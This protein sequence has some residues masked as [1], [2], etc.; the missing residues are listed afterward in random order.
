MKSK[1]SQVKE[2]A[3][4]QAKCKC[5]AKNCSCKSQEEVSEKK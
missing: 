2:N 1:K 4:K 5:K 3:T